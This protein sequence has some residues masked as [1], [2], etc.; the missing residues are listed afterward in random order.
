MVK[1]VALGW[2]KGLI[3]QSKERG[4]LGCW[5]G[6]LSRLDQLVQVKSGSKRDPDPPAE[7]NLFG[8]SV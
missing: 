8:R 4:D 1:S 6:V 5:N 3:E 7:T 2:V